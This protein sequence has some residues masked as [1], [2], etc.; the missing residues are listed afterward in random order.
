M[1]GWMD[2]DGKKEGKNSII[3]ET[4]QRGGGGN[5]HFQQVFAISLRKVST[6]N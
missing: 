4:Q 6:E 2:A 5:L 3:Q 1:D